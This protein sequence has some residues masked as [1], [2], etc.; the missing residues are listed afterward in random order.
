M[1]R[2]LGPVF[3][4]GMPRSGT[5]MLR[6][7]LTSHE[8]ICI[9][10]ESPFMITLHRRFRDTASFDRSTAT[11]FLGAL[12]DEPNSLDRRW[13]TPLAELIDADALVG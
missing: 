5:T 6:L 7:A 12:Q 4:I 9:P 10:P 8:A 11:A 2:M 3:V 1:T 13:Q